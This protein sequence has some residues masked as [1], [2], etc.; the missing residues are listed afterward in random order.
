M[1]E[2]ERTVSTGETGGPLSNISTTTS[3]PNV[4][5]EVWTM[6]LEYFFVDGDLKTMQDCR[7]V[8][9]QWKDI[10]NKFLEKLV[11]SG[12]LPVPRFPELRVANVRLPNGLPTIRHPTDLL[13][14]SDPFPLKSLYLI[15]KYNDTE[16]KQKEA[17]LPMPFLEFVD[18]FGSNLTSFVFHDPIIS[19]NNLATILGSLQSLKLFSISDGKFQ[20]F[21]NAS[22]AVFPS[23]L[24]HP[25][26][27]TLVIKSVHCI[28]RLVRE[29][30]KILY[31][32]LVCSYAEQ[33]VC[34]HLQTGYCFPALQQ[35]HQYFHADREKSPILVATTSASAFGKLEKLKIGCPNKQFFEL[36]DIPALRCLSVVGVAKDE[37]RDIQTLMTCID[38][39]KS[40]IEKLFLDV[41][42]CE[43]MAPW[44]D[45]DQPLPTTRETLPSLKALTFHFP[46]N[47]QQYQKV[48]E[49]TFLFKFPA[50]ETLQLLCFRW[51]S[52]K[53]MRWENEAE[54]S[55]KDN[56]TDN[57]DRIIEDAGKMDS[58]RERL[59]VYAE[60]TTGIVRDAM[61]KLGVVL[62]E[63]NNALR[64]DND[65]VAS[66]DEKH[67]AALM[68]YQQAM[69]ASNLAKEELGP[70]KRE[71]EK[72][73][74]LHELLKGEEVWDNFAKLKRISV[75]SGRKPNGN[76]CVRG[77]PNNNNN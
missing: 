61:L 30:R 59:A 7:L 9:S 57:P 27:T 49:E 60:Q 33:L 45:R 21:S 1:S 51:D 74:V 13:T 34:L 47:F 58:F 25:S 48:V 76:I 65:L 55:D 17:K 22:D 62:E 11:L 3:M 26:L 67:D 46:L 75:S 56:H 16:L 12:E 72:Y 32:W 6:I 54:T 19:I 70:A 39:F 71:A 50:L 14:A 64:G 8:S 31:Q 77:R 4:P 41:S 18:I 63:Y 24:P 66:V 73:L 20:N 43:F 68:E 28:S 52:N 2:S 36:S 23:A 44:I 69:R 38:K 37:F 5:V 29:Q 10:V 53:R 15:R 42:M 40:T 35:S